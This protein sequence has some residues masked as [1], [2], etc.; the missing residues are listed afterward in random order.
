[1]SVTVFLL[2]NLPEEE[3]SL[4]W[5]VDQESCFRIDSTLFN[6]YFQ[7]KGQLEKTKEMGRR[8]DVGVGL[9]LNLTVLLSEYLCILN[10]STSS[11]AVRA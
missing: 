1:M 8:A 3:I 9:I 2:E 7:Q 10:L 6:R 5:D 4:N 11:L